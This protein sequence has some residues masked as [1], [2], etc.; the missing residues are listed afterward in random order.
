MLKEACASSERVAYQLTQERQAYADLGA[1]LRAHPPASVLTV[2]RGSSDHAANYAAYLIMARLGRLVTSLP[3]SLVT[4]NKAPLHTKDTLAIAISQSGQSPDVVEPISYFRQGGATTVAL[5]ND[6]AS[7]LAQAAEWTMP[8]HAGPELSVAATKSFITS[9][10][11]GARLA[12]HWQNDADFLS[13]IDALPEALHAATQLDWSAALD[14]LT[15]AQRI[16]VVGRGI[17]FPVA[18]ESALKFKE[19]SVI[20]AEAFSGAEIKHGPMALIHDGYPLLIFATRGA[21]QEGL[22][23][24]AEEMRGRGANVLLAAPDNVAERNLTLPTAATPDL[25]PIVAIQAF[26]VMAAHLSVA[27]GLNPDQPRH[28][29]KVT[30]TN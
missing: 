29:S 1:H 14:V 20:Q 15:P 19:T 16:M 10:V 21:A 8:L 18:L 30:K 23:R 28:L 25:D 3:M 9:L 26:Y 5:V 6:A 7:P 24:L 11:A 13:A 4:L 12:G 27:R 22:I 17:S 2:A